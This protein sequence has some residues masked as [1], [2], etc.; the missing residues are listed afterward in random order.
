MV[1]LDRIRLTGLL[2]RKPWKQGFLYLCLPA[3]NREAPCG[4]KT[5]T[6]LGDTRVQGAVD[7]SVVVRNDSEAPTVLIVDDHPDSHRL[8]QFALR[9][10][11]PHC[12]AAWDG[13]SST[14]VARKES[15]KAGPAGDPARRGDP[16]TRRRGLLTKSP[17][18]D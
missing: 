16:P 6:Q 5:Q 18:G 12:V 2:R 7:S 4:R 14:A 10:L 3:G 17:A 1:T 15:P 13:I 11:Q 8:T 9:S